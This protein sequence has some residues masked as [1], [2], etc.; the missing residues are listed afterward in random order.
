MCVSVGVHVCCKIGSG[1]A[2]GQLIGIGRED[3]PAAGS[4]LSNKMQPLLSIVLLSFEKD[5]RLYLQMRE[6]EEGEEEE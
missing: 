3:H 1:P 4:V 6:R 2:C 5:G